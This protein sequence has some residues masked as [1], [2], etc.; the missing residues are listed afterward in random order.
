MFKKIHCVFAVVLL[1]QLSSQAQ[2]L[3][4][5]FAGPQA[6]SALYKVEAQKQE[7]SYKYGLQ[8]GV[9]AKVPFESSLFFT[10]S[11]YYSMKGYEVILKDPSFPPGEDATSNDVRIH[12]I[13][14][15]PLFQIDFSKK[16]GHLFVRFGPSVE[17]IFSGNEKVG[18]KNNTTVERSMKF[19]FADYGRLTAS[20]VGQFGYESSNGLM[21]FAHY[22]NG[23]GSM[24]NADGGPQITHRVAGVSFGKYIG[25][26]KH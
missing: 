3:Y 17:A 2:S 19:S 12:S 6:T 21:V 7:T 16:P 14:I 18:L 4:G 13:D 15:A 26:S 9:L 10:P 23:L 20:A 11:L 25:R 24:N 1:F 8:A 5:L 22:A